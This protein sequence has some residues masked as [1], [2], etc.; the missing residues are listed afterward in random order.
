MNTF[1]KTF[2]SWSRGVWEVVIGTVLLFQ[3]ELSKYTAVSAI[4][5]D[6]FTLPSLLH[7]ALPKAYFGYR[8]DQFVFR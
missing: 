1:N 4:Q 6:F 8:N 2:C 3:I 5:D 7:R